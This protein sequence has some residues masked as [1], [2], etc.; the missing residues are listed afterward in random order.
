MDTQQKIL[1]LAS[2][3]KIKMAGTL[4]KLF[5]RYEC[6]TNCEKMNLLERLNNARQAEIAT[7]WGEGK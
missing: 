6:K 2:K 5:N 3:L 7:A 4:Q 1:Y